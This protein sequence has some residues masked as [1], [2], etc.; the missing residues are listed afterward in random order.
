MP[1]SR[2]QPEYL[3]RAELG[4]TGYVRNRDLEFS[5]KDIPREELI[6]KVEDTISVIEKTMAQLKNEQ[7]QEEYPAL[8]F[9]EKTSTEY[10]L[11]HLATH[12]GYHL[13]QVNYHRRLLDGE[14]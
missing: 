8:V 10:M 12:L 9:Q 13:G 7:L 3:Y 4:K 14:K 1:A 11:V 5:Q 6:K 2:R